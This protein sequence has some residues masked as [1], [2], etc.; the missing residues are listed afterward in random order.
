MSHFGPI[1]K[2]DFEEQPAR[3]LIQ[4]SDEEEDVEEDEEEEKEEEEEE[5]EEYRKSNDRQSHHQ[6]LQDKNKD[7][8]DSYTSKECLIKMTLHEILWLW[9]F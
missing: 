4:Y 5:E 8:E 2:K 1:K 6:P 9:C 3:R 7:Y